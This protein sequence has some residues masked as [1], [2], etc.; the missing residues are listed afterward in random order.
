MTTASPNNHQT[1]AVVSNW[2]ALLVLF[3]IERKK[4][5][6]TQRETKLSPASWLERKVASKLCGRGQICFV[7]GGRECKNLN[8]AILILV[9]SF[10]VLHSVACHSLCDLVVKESL[11]LE[12]SLPP[13]FPFIF[14]VVLVVFLSFI[15]NSIPPQELCHQLVHKNEEPSSTA[16]CVAM[17][18]RLLFSFSYTNHLI[19]LGKCISVAKRL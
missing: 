16:W 10:F 7:K 5:V 2:Q 18:G 8:F 12:L 15:H 14:S 19:Q 17:F 6:K 11:C 9:Y 3:E 13:L 4:S 1:V